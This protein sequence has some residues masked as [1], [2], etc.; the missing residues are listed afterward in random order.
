M[1]PNNNGANSRLAECAESKQQIMFRLP[2]QALFGQSLRQKF[3]GSNNVL[4]ATA[5]AWLVEGT[6]AASES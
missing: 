6:A 3:C 4:R 5:C 1:T 2:R